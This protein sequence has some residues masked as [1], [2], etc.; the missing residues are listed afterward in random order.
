MSEQDRLNALAEYEI[1]DTSPESDFDDLVKLAA[2]IFHVP[3]STVTIIDAHRQWF[4]AAVGLTVKETPLDIS[5]CTHAIQS[6]HP[7]IVEDL[8]KDIRFQASPLVT[9]NPK[10]NFYAGVTLIGKDQQAI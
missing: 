1:L 10:I 7:L 3:I 8:T 6:E 4:K 5:V 2:K 9:T